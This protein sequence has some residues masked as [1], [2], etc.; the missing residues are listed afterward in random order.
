MARDSKNGIGSECSIMKNDAWQKF[1][2]IDFLKPADG[3]RT[4][5]AILST[6]SFD[7]SVVVLALLALSGYEMDYGRKGSRV[8]LVK[9]LDSLRHRVCVIAQQA[10]GTIPTAR[11]YVLKLLDRFVKTMSMDEMTGSW[12]PKAALCRY[13]RLDDEDDEQ[14]R[15]WVGSMNLVKSMNWEAG[16]GLVSR[17][18]GKG[19]VVAGLPTLG[20]ELAQ[21]AKLKSLDSRQVKTDLA[22]LTWEFL[23]GN[24]IEAIE[25]YGPQLGSGFPI[26][27]PSARSVFVISPFLDS[28]FV[29]TAARWGE[30]A[31]RT[32]VSTG[33]ELQRLWAANAKV[34]EG[35]SKILTLP[36]PDL[37]GDEVEPFP[38]DE[39]SDSAP[40]DDEEDA[41]AGLHAKLFYFGNRTERKLLLGSA[42]ATSRGWDGRNYEVVAEII[43]SRSVVETLE[44]FIAQ[45][46]PW[47]SSLLISEVEED[48]EAIERARKTL[49]SWSLRQEVTEGMVNVVAKTPPPIEDK[50]KLEIAL[51]NS[52]WNAWPNHASSVLAAASFKQRSDFV[53][54]RLSINDKMSRWLQTAPCD[55]PPDD[56]RDRAVIARYLDPRMFLMWLRSILANDLRA[57]GGDWDG[58]DVIN[59]PGFRMEKGDDLKMA[60]TVEEVLRAWAKDPSTFKE[61]DERVTQ[62][63]NA[64]QERALETDDKSAMKLLEEF[65]QMW[66]TLASEL[67]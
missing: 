30:H 38:T 37:P 8:E 4:K 65:R 50:F 49:S 45:C 61:A 46:T 22:N 20:E 64:F 44:E 34:F 60:P 40:V 52:A 53:Q 66:T 27:N 41:P 43:P 21:R 58:P 2:F 5:H 3:W 29:H 42:N 11:L 28:T 32:L 14:W 57:S 18:D 16:V 1:S 35:F 33:F 10:K 12:H 55:P 6:Y 67:R 63:V 7:L 26:T 48:E 24:R 31:D 23:V 19:Q 36:A 13:V 51:M 15:I 62:Y 17:A 54:L 25:L 47:T 9:A 59:E 39:T 56:D